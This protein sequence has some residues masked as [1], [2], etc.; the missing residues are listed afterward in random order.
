MSTKRSF[1]RDA[2]PLLIIAAVFIGL[3]SAA[4]IG[5][6]GLSG[7]TWVNSTNIDADDFYRGGE[8]FTSWI[9]TEIA[10]APGGGGDN[11]TI[12][13]GGFSVATSIVR[14]NG[15][16]TDYDCRDGTTGAIVSSHADPANAIE[17]MWA[18]GGTGYT[19][20]AGQT[21][22]IQTQILGQGDY[23]TWNSDHDL[24]IKAKVNLNDHMIEL[25][26]DDWIVFDGV[27]LHGNEDNQASDKNGIEATHSQYLDFRNLFIEECGQYG[28]R[29]R[30]DS[31]RNTFVVRIT[32]G[33]F[34]HNGWNGITVEDDISSIFIDGNYVANSSDVG[35]SIPANADLAQLQMQTQITCTN[36]IVEDINLGEGGG[37][38]AARGI[39]IE[40]RAQKVIVTGNQVDLCA[41]GISVA[42]STGDDASERWIEHIEILI[43]NNIL[44]NIGNA[45]WQEAIA[46]GGAYGETGRAVISGNYAHVDVSGAAC[47]EITNATNVNVY[48]NTFYSATGGSNGIEAYNADFNNFAENIINV[49]GIGIDL[50]GASDNNKVS[51][52]MIDAGVDGLELDS[53][54]DETIV[55]GNDFSQSANDVDDNSGQTVHYGYNLSDGGAWAITALG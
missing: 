33:T 44:T 32:D 51:G 14:Y 5:P 24:I 30:S 49:A 16:T 3:I 45:A 39:S 47:L 13:G 48:G 41:I 25:D 12:S 8:N 7:F 17:A 18:R 21:W 38:N 53:G 23:F 9:E 52:N 34:T 50:D 55:D 36:N 37:G 6:T 46:Y 20:G 54:C 15:S 28:I 40:G 1:L 10:A 42:T 35:I 11:F 31:S 19:E 2:A 26:G 43:S 29:V 27:R 4:T 22:T